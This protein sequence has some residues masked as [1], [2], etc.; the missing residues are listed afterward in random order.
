[1]NGQGGV[2]GG[3]DYVMKPKKKTHTPYNVSKKRKLF[4][5]RVERNGKI[6]LKK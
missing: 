5:S 2:F 1:M 4:V 6:C 3:N